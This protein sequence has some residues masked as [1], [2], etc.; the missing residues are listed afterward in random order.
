MEQTFVTSYCIHQAVWN[1]IL[2][3]LCCT[4]LDVAAAARARFD[5]VRIRQ[6]K[7][8]IP[9]TGAIYIYEVGHFTKSA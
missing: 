7:S 6:L 9:F 3:S 1:N 4:K 2:E 8:P 5:E